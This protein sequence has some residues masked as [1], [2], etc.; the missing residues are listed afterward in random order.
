MFTFYLSLQKYLHEKKYA[1]PKNRYFQQRKKRI[2][3]INDYKI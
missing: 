1:I 3:L 2:I